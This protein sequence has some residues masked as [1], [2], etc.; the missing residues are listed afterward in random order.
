MKAVWSLWT[1][2]LHESRHPG[3]PSERHHA[4]SWILS[5]ETARRHY[6]DTCVITDTPG[7]AWLVEGL[8]LPFAEVRVELDD[9]AGQ[10][11]D[12][13]AM[14]KLC[15][16]AAQTEPFVHIDSDVY[17]WNRLPERLEQA[18]VFA[19]NPEWHE[20]GRSF[21]RPE[22]LEYWIGAGGGWLPLEFSHYVHPQGVLRAE[23]CGILGGARVDF[24]THYARQAL[25]IIRHPGNQPLW[26]GLE[27]KDAHFVLIEQ[28]FLAAC[29]EFHR[30]HPESEFSGITIEYLF[31]SQ[32]AA[33]RDAD[34]VGYTH[35]LASA[36]RHG[37]ALE[38]LERRVR[39]L[40]PEQYRRCLGLT[41]TTADPVRRAANR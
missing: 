35:L 24:I 33:L 18:P 10:Q 36:K 25:E 28:Y 27:H 31:P 13:W 29:V 23:N 4:L 8:G 3:W 16:Y 32:S 7:A 30:S 1:R 22:W 41:D 17:L 15:A 26:P 19:Q 20:Y 37:G 34:A 21:Y 5:F 11:A 12:W 14:S 6:P 38:R 2:P 9:L 39:D 40:Y